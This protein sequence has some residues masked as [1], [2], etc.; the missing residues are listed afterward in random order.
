V[1]GIIK[2]ATATAIVA[3]MTAQAVA[4]DLDDR[5][6]RPLDLPPKEKMEFVQPQPLVNWTGFYAGGHGGYGIATLTDE[7]SPLGLSFESP[8]VGA[9]VGFDFA[10]GR[11]VVGPVAEYNIITADEIDA[12]EWAVG[13]RGGIVVAPATM[14]Y[15]KVMLTQLSIEPEGGGTETTIDGKRLAGGLETALTGNL[16]ANLETSYT[17]YDLPNGYDTYYDAGD[18]RALAGLKFKLNGNLLKFND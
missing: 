16:F 15:A 2:L 6:K 11:I 17:W 8:F 7:D 14:A 1:T 9:S 18:F 13:L 10:V 5:R 3:L 4:G 12:T